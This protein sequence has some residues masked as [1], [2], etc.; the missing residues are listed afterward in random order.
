MEGKPA[1]E[2]VP[3]ERLDRPPRGA[4]A[5]LG[6][7]LLGNGEAIRRLA[8]TPRLWLVGLLF[9]FSA[10]LAREYDAED[11]LAEPWH[12][13]IAPGA[14]LIA[15]TALW[16]FV[17]LSG[18][19]RW[20]WSPAKPLE[21]STQPDTERGLEPPPA[22][23][24]SPPRLLDSYLA[25]LGLFWLTAP[26][27][28]LYGIPFERF[29]SAGE[30]ASS[31]LWM[32]TVIALWRVVLMIRV[33][34]VLYGIGGVVASIIVLLF[35]TV[36]MLIALFTMPVP[37]F[38]VMGGVRLGDADRSLAFLAMLG[39]F[40]GSIAAFVLLLLWGTTFLDKRRWTW[41]I[42]ATTVP[43]RRLV[44]LALMASAWW[45]LWLPVTQPEQRLRV[46]VERALRADDFATGLTMLASNPPEAFPPHWDPPP[47]I[48]YT[49]EARPDPGDVLLYLLDHPH[50]L[51]QPHGERCLRLFEAKLTAQGWIYILSLRG[52]RTALSNLVTLLERMPDAGRLM[53]PD[54]PPHEQD[55][56]LYGLHRVLS[57]VDVT[58]DPALKQ[59]IN[60]L[61]ERYPLQ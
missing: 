8:A 60:A 20:V 61:L 6:L 27:A 12:V 40:F 34:Q 29:Q 38:A 59:R 53:H 4:L 15:A 2:P 44:S 10:G 54:L 25:F 31:N 46:Q 52:K 30:A 33:L 21:S 28:W 41:Q 56:D 51:E 11:L 36:L 35:G 48:G 37:I 42:A 3:M 50:L 16:L 57:G 1:S 23:P 17:Q 14:S 55:R 18:I 19:R 9:T 58:D 39:K 26:L 47:R 45:C 49:G 32:L 7:F 13:L 24:P 22:N 5:T 43:L